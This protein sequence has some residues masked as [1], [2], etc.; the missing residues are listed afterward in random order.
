MCRCQGAGLG[1]DLIGFGKILS[2]RGRKDGVV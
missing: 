2:G 1:L